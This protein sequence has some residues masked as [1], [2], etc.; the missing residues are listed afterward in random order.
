MSRG[1]VEGAKTLGFSV[2]KVVI[3]YF[4]PTNAAH[5]IKLFLMRR[6]FD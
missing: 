3:G 4:A 5:R 2:P 6:R 1:D